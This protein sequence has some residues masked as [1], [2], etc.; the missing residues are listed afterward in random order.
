MPS[1]K[2]TYKKPRNKKDTLSSSEWQ[3]LLILRDLE[4]Q[5]SKKEKQ[6]NIV[7]WI[8]KRVEELEK[9]TGW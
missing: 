8:R 2:P 1:K 6:M 9:R 4:S 5:L 3:L 7:Q